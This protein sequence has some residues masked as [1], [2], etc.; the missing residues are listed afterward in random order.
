MQWITICFQ[1]IFYNVKYSIGGALR[2]YD[3]ELNYCQRPKKNLLGFTSTNF[4]HLG[5]INQIYGFWLIL[6]RKH[7][8][9]H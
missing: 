1:K 8:Y 4:V 6:A 5:K 9:L 2:I 7:F 3:Y